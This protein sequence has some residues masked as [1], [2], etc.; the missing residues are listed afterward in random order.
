MKT[1]ISAMLCIVALSINS[2]A[3]S[4]HSSSGGIYPMS[5]QKQPTKTQSTTVKSSKSNS[6]EKR[7][8]DDKTSQKTLTGKVIRV[9]QKVKTFGVTASGKE[10]TFD[11]QSLRTLPAVG[12]NIDITYTQTASGQMQASSFVPSAITGKVIRVNEKEKTFV[13]VTDGKE[14]TLTALKMKV[15]PRVGTNIRVNPNAARFIFNSC[16]ECNAKCPG[17]CFLGPSYCR[18]YLEP[19]PTN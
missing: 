3:T 2:Q 15:L 5:S 13:V 16:E 6:S 14:V 11:A 7:A 10:V 19:L 12:D 18:C 9:D 8:A 4:L 17:V 1:L